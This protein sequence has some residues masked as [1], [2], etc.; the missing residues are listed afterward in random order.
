MRAPSQLNPRD[1]FVAQAY[2]MVKRFQPVQ[3][4]VTL[5]LG[6]TTTDLAPA[7]KSKSVSCLYLAG[8]GEG[9]MFAGANRA[10]ALAMSRASRLG[11]RGSGS[12]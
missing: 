6:T 5:C 12:S 9:G 3:A 11:R 8:H 7:L 1:L 2:R 4:H 10:G